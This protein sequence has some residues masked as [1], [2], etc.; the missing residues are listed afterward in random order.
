MMNER[1]MKLLAESFLSEDEDQ[2][3]DSTSD[4]VNSAPVGD[5]LGDAASEDIQASQETSRLDTNPE[6]KAPSSGLAKRIKRFFSR[7]KN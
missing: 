3:I 2:E 6:P 7:K 5:R 4:E 1:R